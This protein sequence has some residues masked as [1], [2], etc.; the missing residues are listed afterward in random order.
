MVPLN[1][2]KNEPT[3]NFKNNL[4]CGA[5]VHDV[6]IDVTQK[7]KQL[8]LQLKYDHKLVQIGAT[9]YRREVLYKLVACAFGAPINQDQFVQ[10]TDKVPVSAM[11]NL[12]HIQIKTNIIE[13]SRLF[14]SGNQNEIN[15][16]F[17]GVRPPNFP[18]IRVVQFAEFVARLLFDNT[19]LKAIEDLDL[20]IVKFK[21]EEVNTHLHRGFISKGMMDQLIIN[22]FLPYYYYLNET[23]GIGRIIET[24][25]KLKAEKNTSSLYCLRFTKSKCVIEI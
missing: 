8:A 3:I 2:S 18:T 17:K 20:K 23:K 16:N 22:A 25:K 24:L 21:I 9:S 11:L 4:P 12:S 5:Y 6:P 7:T 1:D 15:W 10:L 14:D 19:F 13:E